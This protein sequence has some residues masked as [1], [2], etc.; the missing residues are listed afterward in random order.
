M[1]VFWIVGDFWDADDWDLNTSLYRKLKQQAGQQVW[2]IRCGSKLKKLNGTPPEIARQFHRYHIIHTELMWVD[3]EP[4]EPDVDPDKRV[5]IQKPKPNTVLRSEPIEVS[6]E[7]AE[8][9]FDLK[10][11]ELDPGSYCYGKPTK[12][13]ENDFEDQGEVILDQETGLMWQKSGSDNQMKYENAGSYVKQL[14][15]DRFAGYSD[16]R[17]PTVDEL[18]SLLEEDKKENDLY[19]SPI[20]DVKERFYWC[21]TSDQRAGG[22]AWS[23]SFNFG[24]V[25]WGSMDDYDCVRVCRS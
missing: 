12:F 25:D 18:G 5:P 4:P 19:L 16:W 7:D 21:W 1:Q 15:S 6:D 8:K 24:L 17:L 23:V 20:F 13:V 10:D 11:V 22:G 9:I 2:F 14:N 3:R